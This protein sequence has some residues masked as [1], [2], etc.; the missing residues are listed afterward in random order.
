MAIMDLLD[1]S[2]LYV[3]DEKI[4]RDAI[5]KFLC[6]KVKNV[7]VAADGEEGLEKF[8]KHRPDMVL[9]DVFIPKM[10]GLELIEKIKEIDNHVITIFIS[11]YSEAENILNAIEKGVNAFLIKPIRRKK[12]LQEVEKFA[13]I[14]LLG[15]KIKQEEIERKKAEQALVESEHKFRAI[16]ESA[17]DAIV[18][19]NKKN[20]IT[21]WNSAA[22]EIFDYSKKDV[23]G[24]NLYEKIAPAKYK[25]DFFD[26][27]AKI[28][29]TK[30]DHT[31]G[32]T[33]ELIAKKKDGAEFPLELS[34]SSVNIENEWHTIAILRDISFRK[35]A[36][37]KIKRQHE[38]LEQEI[39]VASSVQSYMLPNWMVKGDE[40]IFTSTYAPSRKLGGDL[41]DII[42]ISDDRYVAY[43]ADISGHGVQAA[44]LMTAVKST[45]SMIIEAAKEK[46]ELSLILN[47]LNDILSKRLFD[48]NFLTIIL[49]LVDLKK[50]TITYY[51]AGHPPIIL[52]D[53]QNG[54]ATILSEKGSI[55]IGWN[56]DYAFPPEEE[57]VFKINENMVIFLY[58]D[59]IFECYN[60]SGEQLGIDGFAK[61]ISNNI[62]NFNSIILPQKI[63]KKLIELDY[64]ISSDDFTLMTIRKIPQEKK[65]EI[66]RSFV[67]KALLEKAGEVA[68]NCEQ[69]IYEKFH[70]RKFA[71]HIELIVDEFLNNIIRHGLMSKSDS[72]IMI[73]LAEDN[74]LKL[75]IWDKGKDWSL[76]PF[77]EDGKYFP[78]E[79]LLDELGRG[80]FVIYTIAS[81]VIKQRFGEINETVIKIPY[82]KQ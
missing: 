19:I 70:D 74:E 72:M 66:K 31:K 1:I 38:E 75:T 22:V 11:G 39:E 8:I 18:M 27:F 43:V 42:Q 62:H 41:L 50:N 44:I 69:F 58:T 40:V 77:R 23:L 52:Y 54:K 61:F 76:P 16:T 53:I 80:I 15:K 36:E 5:T 57:D 63:K 35:N 12:L 56:E 34:V 7:Y 17:Y 68:I 25:Q 10:N 59:G 29:K 33:L 3:E 13:K 51:N 21:Y 60:K 32:K 64:D 2:V 4:S 49:C 65:G 79:K 48:I 46:L 45:I 67:L 14:I 78:D 26:A 9:A 20:E 47:R 37:Q 24:K 81:E 82:R 55:P 6:S 71:S 28:R 30:E 73:Q